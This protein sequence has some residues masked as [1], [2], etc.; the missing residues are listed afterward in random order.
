MKYYVYILILSNGQYYTGS[1]CNIE[2]RIAEHNSGKTVSIRH[3]LPAILT[4][5]QE[6]ISLKEARS[7]ENYIKKQK[8]RIFIEKIISEGFVK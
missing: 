2:R 5:K 3:K 7:A 1:T 4:F 6:F 8:S